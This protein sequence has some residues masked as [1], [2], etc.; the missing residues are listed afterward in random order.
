MV[1]SVLT[2][3][4]AVTT[5]RSSRGGAAITSIGHHHTAGTSLEV[6]LGLFQPG[7]RTVSPNYCIRGRDIVLVVPEEYRA[8]TSADSWADGQSITYEIVNSTGSPYWQFDPETIE[9]V[10]RLDAD[11]SRRYGIQVRHDL[12]GFWE[13]KNLYQ[14]FGRSYAT[15][16]AGPSFDINY[17]IGRVA[18]TPAGG[19]YT[20]IEEDEMPE[21]L[22]NQRVGPWSLAEGGNLR[23]QATPPKTGVDSLSKGDGR[24]T[25]TPHVY[26]RDL[27]EGDVLE[28]EL[29]WHN[30]KTKT[31]SA[32]YVE[33]IYGVGTPE[34][35]PGGEFKH[36]T[37]FVRDVTNGFVVVGR[38]RAVKG[39][40]VITVTG[41]ESLKFKLPS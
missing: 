25:F 16:C 18:T 21:L 12:P 23:F 15:A 10:I 41:C 27:Y 33:R 32:H 35:N 20:P 11:I 38:V 28:L 30:P 13:H 4:F 1:H 6:A 2:T 3:R 34:T 40:A 17:I 39:S 24:Y 36:T 5:D 19:G 22:F 9:S 8:W 31:E 14:W 29:L 7:G 26:G 37:T